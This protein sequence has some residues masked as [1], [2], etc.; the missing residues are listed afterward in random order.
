MILSVLKHGE[1]VPHDL[2]AMPHLVM[3]AIRQGDR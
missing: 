1:P 3:N 2:D